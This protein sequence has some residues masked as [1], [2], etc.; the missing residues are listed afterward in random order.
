MKNKNCL[1]K[2]DMSFLDTDKGIDDVEYFRV[3]DGADKEITARIYDD[4]IPANFAEDEREEKADFQAFYEKDE[5]S[6]ERREN[7]NLAAICN[8]K[9]VG[10]M[11]GMAFHKSGL[12]YFDYLATD[13]EYRS[14]GIGTKLFSAG[15][16]ILKDIA[17][18]H[19]YDNDE[20]AALLIVEKEDSTMNLDKGQDPKRRLH[21]YERQGCKKVS[22]MPCIV[23]GILDT[24]TGEQKPPLIGVYNWLAAP[25][26]RDFGSS[27]PWISRDRALQLN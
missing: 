10:F 7:I 8:G 15:K 9:F 19:G 5:E 23:P 16:K 24:E 3:L 13:E 11:T 4:L 21:F 1:E 22:G 26:N 20:L 2:I 27:E 18:Q 17:G 12:G 25:V 14:H 6:D